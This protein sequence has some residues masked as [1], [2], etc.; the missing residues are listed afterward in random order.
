MLHAL[1]GCWTVASIHVKFLPIW[2]HLMLNW[3]MR[4]LVL[5]VDSDISALI[6]NKDP[7]SMYPSFILNI[8]LILKH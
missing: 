7:T 3:L 8:G 5:G 2:K 4:L 6:A 1:D